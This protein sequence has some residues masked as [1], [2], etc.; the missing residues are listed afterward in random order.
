MFNKITWLLR[1]SF[2]SPKP[3]ELVLSDMCNQGNKTICK[4]R[5]LLA[6][7]AGGLIRQVSLYT[8]FTIS[9]ELMS[10]YLWYWFTAVNTINAVFIDYDEQGIQLGPTEA[11]RYW[12]YWVPA[13]YVDAIKDAILG[14]W[15][16]FWHP[17]GGLLLDCDLQG[18]TQD[19][20]SGD[21]P[22]TVDTAIGLILNITVMPSYWGNW[23]CLGQELFFSHVQVHFLP[24]IF[25]HSM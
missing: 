2:S 17:L 24:K 11:S 1:P 19:I 14:K 15:Q 20:Q 10:K 6:S 5:P 18:S 9:S 7:P 16:Y 3:H 23:K 25:H 12:V 4:L 13:Q 22:V 21:I 8:K